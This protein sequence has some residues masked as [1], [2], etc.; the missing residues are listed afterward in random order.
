MSGDSTEVVFKLNV[1]GEEAIGTRAISETTENKIEKLN[2]YIFKSSVAPSGDPNNRML[3]TLMYTAAPTTITDFGSAP[4]KEKRATVK[5][6]S[7][8]VG[9]RFIIIANQPTSP[10]ITYVEGKTTLA[11]LLPQLKFAAAAWQDTLNMYDAPAVPP[12]GEFTPIPMFGQSTEFRYV[13][14]A[15]SG[16]NPYPAE[17]FVDMIRSLAKVQ[18]RVDINNNTG[19][20]ALGGSTYFKIDSVY[21]CNYADSGYIAPNPLYVADAVP[22]IEVP[23]PLRP[24]MVHTVRYAG[25]AVA[26]HVVPALERTIYM[27]EHAVPNNSYLILKAKYYTNDYYYRV[28]F[29]RDTAM[30]VLRNHN[31]TFVITGI[32]KEGFT[33]FAA[34]QDA[35]L[36]V[37]NPHLILN[38]AE[39]KITEIVYNR[40]NYFGIEST[41]AK[42][43]WMGGGLA[44]SFGNLPSLKIQIKT[45]QA[46][47]APEI[48]PNDPT[49]LIWDK[50]QGILSTTRTLEI[51]RE[52]NIYG[53]TKTQTYILKTSDNLQHTIKVIQYPGSYS[54]MVGAGASCIDIPVSS[55]VADGRSSLNS[56]SLTGKRVVV[57]YGTNVSLSG[58]FVDISGANHIIRVFT[59][60]A[61]GYSIIS[62]KDAG[63]NPKTYWSWMIWTFSDV[64]GPPDATYGYTGMPYA[65]DTLRYNGYEFMAHDLGAT[66][67]GA[68]GAYFQWGRK[69]AFPSSL[70]G[71]YNAAPADIKCNVDTANAHP[72]TF[73]YNPISP[74]DWKR[75][76][77]NN[78]M[79]VDVDGEKGPYDP[80][81]FGWRVPPAETDS[82]SPWNGFANTN[83]GL[84]FNSNG[85]IDGLTGTYNT[86]SAYNSYW[87]A[88]ARSTQA[89]SFRLPN[90]PQNAYRA[91]GFS[92]RCVRDNIRRL[93]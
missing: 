54:Y 74:F 90:S 35:V 12:L 84:T 18:L 44:T 42:F 30:P 20:P 82:V 67:P 26:A 38:D 65:G 83:N 32:R 29:V 85:R 91:N 49:R 34:A 9:Q 53:E 28:D 46:I 50:P 13:G 60:G 75:D 19:D 48:I 45:M 56:V 86:G 7:L 64:S 92:I 6:K 58:G 3:D 69:D 24:T 80:C 52:Q 37:L 15:I 62:L 57:D 76:W 87:S 59:T 25:P 41:I 73:F 17:L 21:V 63:A 16:L 61:D 40:D 8:P 10:A 31:Y 51:K 66:T 68:S 1:H 23:N 14:P 11:E 72:L 79:W 39:P 47:D 4:Y 88:S 89:H 71:S 5:L 2:L 81:P 27:T 93:K 43:D 55:A 70:P 78:N 77:Q 36:P 33:S 22:N